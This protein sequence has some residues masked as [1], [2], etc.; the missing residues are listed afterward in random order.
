MLSSGKWSLAILFLL[1]LSLPTAHAFESDG[2]LTTPDNWQQHVSAGQLKQ[3]F[4]GIGLSDETKMYLTLTTRLRLKSNEY[5]DDQDV[6]QYLRMHTDSAKLGSGTVKAALF[7]RIAADINGNSGREWGEN[8]YYI[9]RDILD[10]EASDDDYAGRLYHGY[11][12]F[13]NVVRNTSL[14]AGRIYTDHL[15][16]LHL[17]GADASVRLSDSFSVYAFGGAPVSYYYDRDSDSI[18]GAGFSAAYGSKVSFG[19]EY[20]KIDAEDI[21][22]NYAK[23]RLTGTVKGG[24]VVVEYTD[25]NNSGTF[26]ASADYEIA[27]TGTIINFGYETLTDVIDSDKTYVVNPITYALLPESKYSK[28]SVSVYQAFLRYFAAGL[29]YEA[30]S[31][32]GEGDFDNRDYAKYGC[33]FDING[34]PHKDTYISVSLDKWDVDSVESSNDEDRFQYSVQAGQ[35]VGESFDVWLGSAFSRFEY[36]YSSDKRKDFVR[37]YYVGG[38]YRF[39]DKVSFMVDLNREDTDFYDDS[40]KD[41]SKNYTAEIWANI[42]F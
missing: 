5:A 14:A 9:H 4:A 2:N 16:Q 18:Y 33:R 37:S 20:A 29:S 35:R 8:K 42:V 34:L 36:D 17:D 30:K 11:L 26:S 32:D 13:D 39:S 1:V 22:D 12:Q 21:D 31:V 3:S 7:G 38:E 19:A 41:L 25:L 27:K 6:Y 28:Y 23:L 10:S 40:D 15:N 24:Y